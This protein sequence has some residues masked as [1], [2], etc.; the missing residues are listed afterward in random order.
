[1]EIVVGTKDT[2][3]RSSRICLGKG[4]AII[5]ILLRNPEERFDARIRYG[6]AN[7]ALP[8]PTFPFHEATGTPIRAPQT[9]TKPRSG[10][11]Q[12]VPPPQREHD[13]PE[14]SGQGEGI[15]CIAPSSPAVRSTYQIAQVPLP[16]PRAPRPGLARA[17]AA[18]ATAAAGRLLAGIGV[19]ALRIG[20][21]SR[22]RAHEPRA[23]DAKA[24]IGAQWTLECGATRAKGIT[25]KIACFLYGTVHGFTQLA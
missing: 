16:E 9:G 8:T 3:V 20:A 24:P 5:L 12:R 7:L 17:C 23:K 11:R 4:T 1:M 25:G 2:N 22:V 19:R 10:S 6:N 21:A 14:P 15:R 18:P 13:S